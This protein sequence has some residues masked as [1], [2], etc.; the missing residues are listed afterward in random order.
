M[1]AVEDY[2]DRQTEPV[3]TPSPT[4]EPDVVGDYLT[5]QTQWLGLS[6]QQG[7][8]IPTEQAAKILRAQVKTGLPPEFLQDNLPYVESQLAKKEFD[9]DRFK[10]DSPVV[11]DWLAKHPMN[12]AAAKD[13]HLP[14]G[15]IEKLSGALSKGWLNLQNEGWRSRRA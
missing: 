2:L 15:L 4:G 9:P 11:A 3:A 12:A 13:D 1:G 14:L 7:Q 5:R 10:Q 8:E 6:V